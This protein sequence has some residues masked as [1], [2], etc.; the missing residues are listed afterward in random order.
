VNLHAAFILPH[1][2]LEIESLNFGQVAWIGWLSR[3]LAED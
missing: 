3:L 1:A 2:Y